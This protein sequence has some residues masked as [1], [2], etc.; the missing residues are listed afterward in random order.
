VFGS[1]TNDKVFIFKWQIQISPMELW[2]D[3]KRWFGS[4][5][6]GPLDL[7]SAQEA[8]EIWLS[9][10]DLA[11]FAFVF[12]KGDLL[13]LRKNLVLL[14]IGHVTKDTYVASMRY[15]IT[16]ADLQELGAQ[17]NSVPSPIYQMSTKLSTVLF[18]SI[19][20]WSEE[21]TSMRCWSM[22]T[23]SFLIG[24]FSLYPIVIL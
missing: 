22:I 6:S 16:V 19:P 5:V 9:A 12:W 20:C 24:P 7:W 2:I 13:L 4:L 14:R 11:H 17:A 21:V 1:L 15:N 3:S 10:V 8:W 23:F 18:N